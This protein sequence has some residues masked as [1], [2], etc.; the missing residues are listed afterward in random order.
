MP[1]NSV[2]W[3]KQF[4][5]WFLI[6][7]PASAVIAGFVM[8]WL[9]LNSQHSMVV[10]DYFKYGKTIN[11]RIERDVNATRLGV[12][13]LLESSTNELRVTVSSAAP[14][15]AEWSEQLQVRAVHPSDARRDMTFV[16]RHQRD[17][18][19]L[20]RASLPPGRWQIHIEPVS[21]QWRLV[22]PTSRVEQGTTLN[23]QHRNQLLPSR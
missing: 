4:W 21:G 15:Y 5:P 12:N 13:A 22:S 23:I 10:D 19:Y 2:S 20:A 8:L 3:Y 6:A 7:I 1:D 11:K 18:V 16:L 9:A 14:D 17:G